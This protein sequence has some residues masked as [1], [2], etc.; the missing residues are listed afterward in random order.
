MALKVKQEEHTTDHRKPNA[1]KARPTADNYIPNSAELALRISLNAGVPFLHEDLEKH[2]SF[3]ELR[4]Q[5]DVHSKPNVGRLLVDQAEHRGNATLWR[6]ILKFRQR[7]DGM[8]GV[9]DVWY[10]MRERD[11]D[12][13]TAGEDA[14]FLWTTFTHAAI[15]AS[16]DAS[17]D[18]P[19]LLND[20]CRYARKV[21]ERDGSKY[22]GLHKCIVGRRL[23]VAPADA[24]F[25]HDMLSKHGFVSPGA[26]KFIAADAMTGRRAFSR[27]ARIYH[28]STDRDCYDYCIEQVL[29][30][31]N[32][33][34]ALLWHR[35]FITH[36]DGP[37][38]DTFAKP[39][40]RR[41][42]ELDGDKSLP[43]KRASKPLKMK[44]ANA[45]KAK[46]LVVNRASMNLIVGE[47]H[48]IK[49]KEISDNFCAR[50][51]ATRAFSID[52]VL[53]GL[54]FIGVEKLGPVALREMAIR[55]GSPAEFS[56]KL[57][58]LKARG[59]IIAGAVFSQLL[60]KLASEGRTRLWDVL[61]ESDQHPDS[62]E[63]VPTQEALLSSFLD[64][65]KYTQAHITMMALSSNGAYTSGCVWNRLLQH[66]LKTDEYY[67]MLSTY[68]SIQSEG[69]ALSSETICSMQKYLL[70]TRNRGKRAMKGLGPKFFEPVD[71]VT[72]AL[73]YTAKRGDPVP[74]MLWREQLKRYGMEHRFTRLERL[75]LW[76]YDFY[77][78]R[79]TWPQNR[80]RC[81]GFEEMRPRRL[82]RTLWLVF[83]RAMRRAIITWGFRSASVRDQLRFGKVRRIPVN[84][85][86]T[87]IACE[88][89]ARGLALLKTLR[90]KGD[91][92]DLAPIRREFV[93]RMWIL[94]GPSYSTLAVNREAR[95]NNRFSLQHYINHANLVWDGLVT[96]VDPELLEK[97]H[98]GD[99]RLLPQFFRPVRRVSLK[100]GED[101]D[102]E[103]WARSLARGNS[104]YTCEGR[105]VYQKSW[106][107][108]NSRIRL[109]S[110][111]FPR[112][113]RPHPRAQADLDDKVTLPLEPRRRRHRWQGGAEPDDGLSFLLE[114]QS[115]AARSKNSYPPPNPTNTQATA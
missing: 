63:D 80:G 27:F 77:S 71:M 82:P 109:V 42:F 4:F 65:E 76:L 112:R 34:L 60:V 14:D 11:F 58:D 94:F 75:V 36:G 68:Q 45:E 74:V 26:L 43:M 85:T 3:H 114:H 92:V 7:L 5:A 67:Q 52:L 101:A 31:E 103:A 13:P 2:C 84:A 32:E 28:N 39:G 56:A 62:Y 104:P 66:Y 18:C 57:R 10:G 41:L 20:I 12:L 95:R 50:M 17:D 35:M 98:E 96:W 24:K 81:L 106:S 55:A 99:P 25:W 19:D 59:I 69:L 107:W 6:E 1:V 33:P 37:S 15:S 54:A 79:P 29:K 83:T 73:I 64:R 90:D 21:K 70:P 16:S 44:E 23:R 53:R 46:H 102:V 93:L 86:D 61:L 97:E 40:V 88:S 100:R 91:H 48:G 30:T 115:P 38:S 8:K 9:A 72:N 113:R 51:F 110:N 111:N 49:P 108:R 87:S 47:V 89:W 78:S 105:K 22:E